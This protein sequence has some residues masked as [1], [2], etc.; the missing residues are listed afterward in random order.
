MLSIGGRPVD[1]LVNAAGGTPLFVYDL[2]IV[3]E[4]IARFRAL[5]PDFVHLHYAVKANPYADLL[6]F[7]A[8][9]VDGMDVASAGEMDRAQPL[10]CG[11][12][13]SY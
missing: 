3:A 6:Q 9:I 10:R 5:M 4:R 11:H 12:A 7:V 13:V 1:A 2:A 8:R